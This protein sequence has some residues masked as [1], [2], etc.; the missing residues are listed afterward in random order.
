MSSLFGKLFGGGGDAPRHEA[1][2]ADKTN[3]TASAIQKIQSS[4]ELLQRKSEH[5]TKKMN[6]ELMEAKKYGT[7]NKAKAMHHLKRKKRYE[8]M[9]AQIDGQINTLEAQMFALE[10]IATTTEVTSALSAG[11][12]AMKTAQGDVDKVQDLMDD[13]QDQ[14]EQAS[15]ISNVLSNSAFGEQFDEDE[16]LSELEGI[17]QE[18]LDEQLLDVG[19]LPELD[20][21]PSVPTATVAQPAKKVQNDASELEDL[22]AWA[23]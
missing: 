14:M 10:G 20:S 9:Q 15:E 2:A 18:E 11:H 5:L 8:H 19:G 7:K 13:V 6:Q 12:Q 3:S 23:M 4:V 21:L 1:S 17:E 22:A 16:L